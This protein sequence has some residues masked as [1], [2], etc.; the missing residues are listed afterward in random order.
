MRDKNCIN[1]LCQ[2][3]SMKFYNI[4]FRHIVF[5]ADYNTITKITN[6]IIRR[7]CVTY[8]KNYIL[9]SYKR[10]H[11]LYLLFLFSP[12]TFG[13]N[14]YE[15]P[16]FDLHLRPRKIFVYVTD[17]NRNVLVFLWHENFIHICHCGAFTYFFSYTLNI[18]YSLLPTKLEHF[19]A[20][21]R[22]TDE[23]ILG[24]TLC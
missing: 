21:N 20:H 7:H 18:F 9:I 17:E 1:K 10:T 6:K 2:T 15:N 22:A 5:L 23:M 16:V 4:M 19:A 8:F 13:R 12:Y 14:F 24:I 11:F 3:V